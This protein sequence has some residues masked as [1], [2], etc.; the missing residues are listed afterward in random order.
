MGITQNTGASSLIRPGVIDN[1]AARPASPYEGQ[2]IYQKDTDAVLVWNGTAWYPNWN[3]PWGVVGSVSRTAGNITPTVGS[4]TDVT[5]VSIT[6]TAI[7]NRTYKMSWSCAAEKQTAVGWIAIFLAN[8]ANTIFA[9][10]YG[11]PAVVGAGYTTLSGFH[12]ITGLAAGSY[13]FKL[14]T[15]TENNAATILASGTNPTNFII[16][17]IGPA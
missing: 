11:S 4:A 3:L 10:V 2:V 13:T 7:A 16:E 15:Q 6:F 9:S 1:T 5:G 14:R 8:A 17:D 12:H